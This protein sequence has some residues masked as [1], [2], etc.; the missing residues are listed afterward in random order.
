MFLLDLL[1]L[2]V[3]SFIVLENLCLPI[4][5]EIEQNLM[6]ILNGTGFLNKYSPKDKT[7]TAGES[8]KKILKSISCWFIEML[9]KF[10]NQTANVLTQFVEAILT[11]SNLSN[12]DLSLQINLDI[13]VQYDIA[14]FSV[15]NVSSMNFLCKLSCSREI[16]HRLNCVEIIGKLLLVNSTCNWKVFRNELSGTVREIKMLKILSE[17]LLDINNNVKIKAINAFLRAAAVGNTNTKTILK[18]RNCI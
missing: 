13:C 12:G 8:S 3:K 1:Q 10:P 16:S 6:L 9:D 5:G 11:D 2:Y 15:C 4:Q 17:K 18:V 14:M 7:R